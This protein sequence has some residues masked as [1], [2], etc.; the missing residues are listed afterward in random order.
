MLHRPNGLQDVAGALDGFL[1]SVR[2]RLVRKRER[3]VHFAAVRCFVCFL[4]CSFVCFFRQ[5]FE[6]GFQVGSLRVLRK[7]FAEL[8]QLGDLRGRHDGF[9]S[10]GLRGLRR[11]VVRL[12]VGAGLLRVG[13]CNTSIRF[14]FWTN[15]Q[16]SPSLYS[17]KNN[18]KSRKNKMFFYYFSKKCIFFLFYA[19]LQHF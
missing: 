7:A 8:G 17:P 10:L 1:A 3:S 12:A 6:Q 14:A 16:A 18:L 2:S 15:R 9:V 11:A 13:C 5:T 4:L 19:L